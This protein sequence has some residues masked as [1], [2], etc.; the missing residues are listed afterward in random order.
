MYNYLIDHALQ[1]VWS[2]PSQDTQFIVTP[3]RIS[4]PKGHVGRIQLMHTWT[5]LPTPHDTYHV[6]QIG[7]LHPL[8]LKL[9]FDQDLYYTEGWTSL[10]ETMTQ[11]QMWTDLYTD[12]GVH[13]PHHEVYYRF[14]YTRDLVLAVRENLNLKINPQEDQVFFRVYSASYFELIRGIIDPL[15]FVHGVSSLTAG[16][17]TTLQTYYTTYNALPGRVLLYVNGLLVDTLNSGN[18]PLGSTVEL[19][20]DAA[21]YKV[22]EYPYENLPVF[23]SQVDDNFKYLLHYDK[24]VAVTTIDYFDDTDLYLGYRVNGYLYGVY[25]HRNRLDGCRMLTHRDYSV[26]VDTTA[27]FM[28][29]LQAQLGLGAL[30]PS[31]LVFRL[32]VRR[33]GSNQPLVFE[34]NR[35]HELY[36]LEEPDLFQ[37]LIGTVQGPANFRAE[38]LEA[39]A[40]SQLMRTGSAS[41]LTLDLVKAG[42]GYNAIS[43]ILANTP[44]PTVLY[45]GVQQAPLP[46][47]LYYNSTVYE[48]DADGVLLGYYLHNAGSVYSATNAETRLVEGIVGIGTLAPDTVFGSDLIPLPTTTDYRVYKSHVVGGVPDDLW[49]DITGTEDYVVNENLLHWT[50]VESNQFLMIRTD[51]TFLAYDLNLTPTNGILSFSLQETESRDGITP[52]TYFL[53]VPLGELD[54]FLNGRPLIE[55]LDYFVQF[56]KVVIVNKEYLTAD[57]NLTPQWIHVRFKGFCRADLTYEPPLDVGF[58]QYGFLSNNAK[59]NLRDDKVLRIVVDGALKQRADFTYAEN[60]P[61]LEVI[62]ALNGRPYSIRDLVVPMYSYINQDTYAFRAAS[63]AV[64]TLVS[65]YLTEKLP[66]QPEPNPSSIP[67]KYQVFSPFISAILFDLLE[68]QISNATLS[69]LTNDAAILTFCQA[70][71][72]WLPFDPSQPPTQTDTRYVDIHPNNLFTLISLPVNQYSFLTN[73]V[74]LY[75]HGLVTLS[76]FIVV[77]P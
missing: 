74:R 15:I 4:A 36:K 44:T 68:G 24:S 25:F 56:P 50:G 51:R 72:H 77:A 55:N 10:K 62:N 73:V 52:L 64:D 29:V 65:N 17:L 60:N 34:H 5:P 13:F 75:C 28:E 67:A 14:N 61:P 1:N 70:Y 20:Y 58:I 42:Y 11:S 41:G 40:Y 33:S 3:A 35:I 46:Y 6:F 2:N 16:D 43:R 32:H 23:Q 69:G 48:Y 63:Q 18:A 38:T 59:Y 57:P 66:Q 49:T 7:Q 47:G 45:S 31:Q 71:E 26:P 19:C 12:S 27:R 30:D 53:P 22:I 39:S 8:F 54:L 76:P 21:F 37:A 9:F